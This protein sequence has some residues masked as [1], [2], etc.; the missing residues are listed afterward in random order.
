M[1]GIRV[2]RENGMREREVEFE[3]GEIMVFEIFVGRWNGLFNC[4]GIE[5]E[6]GIRS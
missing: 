4:E 5:G 1:R 2:G 6:V 3:R